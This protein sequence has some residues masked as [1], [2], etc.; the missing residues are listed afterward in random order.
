MKRE[1]EHPVEDLENS[2]KGTEKSETP[3]QSQNTDRL[4]PK[5]RIAMIV[6]YNGSSFNGSQKNPGVRTV[7]EQIEKALFQLNLTSKYNFGDLKK[8]AWTRATRTDKSVHAL[9]NTFSCKV[10]LSKE[11]R[12]DVSG[13][14]DVGLERLRERINN[15]LKEINLKDCPDADPKYDEVKVFCVIEVSNR[16]NAKINT[17]HREY[18]Y[19]LPT[20]TLSSINSDFYLGRKG[21]EIGEPK[22]ADPKDITGQKVING[23]TI[24]ERLANEDDLRDGQ[25]NFMGRDISYL[26]ENKEFMA[27]LYGFRLSPEKKELVHKIFKEKFEGTKKYH[28][29]TRN[30]KPEQQ[31]A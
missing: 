2:V 27:K 10:H 11:D 7:E 18:S 29:Y 23:I 6:G 14:S 15:A 1:A 12:S 3:K 25:E 26:T 24:T 31:A 16:F 22:Q 20:F 8:I 17:S 13:G 19:Y 21:L 9:Q 30:M 4:P 5:V 28:N